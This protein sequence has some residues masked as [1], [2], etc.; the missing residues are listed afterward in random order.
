[1]SFWKQDS[2]ND[3]FMKHPI[4]KIVLT[5]GPGGGKTTAAE[6]FLREYRDRATLVPE[7]ATALFKSGYPRVPDPVA[8]RLMQTSIYNLQLNVEQIYQHLFPNNVLLCDRGTIDGA[9][10]WPDSDKDFF[11]TMK[12]TIEAELKLYDVVLFFETAAAGGFPI[13]LGNK[14]RIEGRD[15]AIELDQ[16]LRK[17]WSQHPRFI[18]IPNHSSFYTKIGLAIKELDLLMS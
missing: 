1:M 7:T 9:A 17:L 15:E 11:S 10:Y 8:I 6:F 4:K 12:T 2:E 16:K 3:M 14:V 5:G 18:F 13:D